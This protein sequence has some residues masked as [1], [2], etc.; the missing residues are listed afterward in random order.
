MNRKDARL[1][2][3]CVAG[4]AINDY[5]GRFLDRYH[6]IDGDERRKIEREIEAIKDRL[7]DRADRNYGS[8]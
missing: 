8:E 4:D 2:A 7:F 5:A 3:L 6:A 1:I